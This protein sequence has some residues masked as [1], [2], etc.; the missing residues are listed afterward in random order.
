LERTPIMKPSTRLAAI[1]GLLAASQAH[2][3]E[4]VL[5]MHGGAIPRAELS[6]EKEAAIRADLEA[7]LR[8]GAKVIADGGSSLD[9]V[10][11]AVV[12]LEDSP[13]FNAGKGAV[14]NADG[15]NELDAS[16]MEG[17]T[18]RAGAVAGLHRIRNPITLARAVMEKSVHVMMI[19][20]GAEK[21]AK[22]VGIE[23]VE[24]SY[25][26]TEARW[27]ELLKAREQEKEK[28]QAGLPLPPSAYYGTVG[29]VARDHDGHLAAAT[30]TGGMTNKRFGRVGDV[31][32][33]GAGTWADTRCA[34]S[35][36]GWGE[37]FIRAAVAHD[38]CARM[39]YRGDSVG[40]AADAAL[41]EVAKLGGNGGVIVLDARGNAALPFNSGG[42]YRGTID[43]DGKVSVAIY[44]E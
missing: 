34:V 12:M 33:I 26:H 39:A 29:A 10:T 7:A 30:S 8:A 2:A 19:G 28:A 1:L 20:E 5:A 27:Q 13:H 23:F 4:I 15:I 36:T 38:I 18:R 42:M 14:F 25:F 40:K 37:M 9:A 24:P 35:S 17:H 44:A 6:E 11:R 3:A 31:P 43:A 16:I 22:S 32:I 21:F 41:A